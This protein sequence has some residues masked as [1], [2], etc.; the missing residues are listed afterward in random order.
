MA[1]K[2]E[3]DV[4]EVLSK[5]E[6]FEWHRRQRRGPSRA[7]RAWND[8]WQRLADRASLRLARFSAGHL[9]LVGFLI[10]VAGLVFRIRGPGLWLMLGGVIIFFLGLAW[11]MRS[12][13]SHPT[14]S[15]RGGFW[16]DRYITYDGE[17]GGP[18]GWFRRW[19]R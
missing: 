7:R 5:I 12:G 10:L 1:D 3:R 15:A 8:S 6:D 19:R 18:R 16:R 9:M 11:S 2:I 4:E 13:G 14:H 17:P